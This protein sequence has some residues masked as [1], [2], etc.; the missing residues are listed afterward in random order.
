MPFFEDVSVQAKWSSWCKNDEK[1]SPDSSSQYL[2][3]EYLHLIEASGSA[4]YE[5][6]CGQRVV[7]VEPQLR[8]RQ[9]A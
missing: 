7:I 1:T 2:T 8:Y 6:L 5:A 3:L 9:S 4:A